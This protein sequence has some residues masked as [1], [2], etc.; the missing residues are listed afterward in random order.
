MLKNQ[1]STNAVLLLA[2]K[3]RKIAIRRPHLELLREVKQIEAEIADD[4]MRLIT[5]EEL[6]RQIA[7]KI[8][9]I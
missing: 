8:A 3:W 5:E 9:S 1:R 6:E 7:E 2:K 4:P